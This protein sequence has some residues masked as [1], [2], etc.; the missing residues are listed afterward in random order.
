MFGYDKNEMLGKKAHRLLAPLDL[1]EKAHSGLKRFARTGEGRALNSPLELQARHKNGKDIYIELHVGRIRRGNRWWGV[2]AAIDISAHKIREK[3]LADEAETDQLTG[4]KN[5]R[6]FLRLAEQALNNRRFDDSAIYL[7]M[8]DLDHFKKINDEH[9]HA[10]GD[11]V[12][13]ILTSQCEQNLRSTDLF[14]R[15][16]G[17]EFAAVMR[18]NERRAI[19]AAADRIRSAFDHEE[20][21]IDGHTLKLRTSVSIGLAQINTPHETLEE[22]LKRADAALYQAKSQ[23]RNRIVSD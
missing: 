5:R 9:G 10:I 17:E 20:L 6:C 11:K 8:L 15:I 16:D 4:V 18:G 12:L 14:G 19:V 1:Q 23:G 22:G 2:G 7:L 21:V 3:M 13:R